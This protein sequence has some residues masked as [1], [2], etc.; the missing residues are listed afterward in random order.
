MKT[1]EEQCNKSIIQTFC[2]YRAPYNVQCVNSL[3]IKI[4]ELC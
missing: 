1:W 2:Q 4:N 3:T